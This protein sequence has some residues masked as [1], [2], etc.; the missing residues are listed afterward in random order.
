MAYPVVQIPMTLSEV[1]QSFLYISYTGIFHSGQFIRLA[2]LVWE[3]SVS[4]AVSVC[5]LPSVV[6]L[7]HVRSRKLC[8]IRAKFRRP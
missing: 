2:H 6:C 5:C 3:P 7:S 4:V 1:V 8:E